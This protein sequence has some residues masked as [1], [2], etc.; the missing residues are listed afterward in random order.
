MTDSR[1][2]GRP[3]SNPESHLKVP[4]SDA[5]LR[6]LVSSIVQETIKQ[7]ESGPR[8][9]LRPAHPVRSALVAI[10]L[11]SLGFLIAT[12]GLF[13]G[14]PTIPAS[15][16]G[17]WVTDAPAYKDR[18]FEIT[19]TSVILNAPGL[20]PRAYPIKSIKHTVEQDADR[21]VIQYDQDG[22]EAELSVAVS[23]LAQHGEIKFTHQPEMSWH[24]GTP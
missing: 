11:V 21:Y 12:S 19:P 18:S 4:R 2:A 5:E 14:P 22:A 20:E 13:Q 15:I 24:R 1:D 23:G 17:T 6:E 16:L 8:N 7:R 10:L 9:L 3:P